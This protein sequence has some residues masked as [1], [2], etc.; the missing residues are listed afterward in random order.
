MKYCDYNIQIDRN[1]IELD[2]ELTDKLIPK[3]EW[4]VGDRWEMMVVDGV[5]TLF[6]VNRE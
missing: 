4:T 3:L 1:K 5:I 6:K 2:S